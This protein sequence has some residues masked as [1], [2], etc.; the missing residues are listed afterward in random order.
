MD[1][2]AFLLSTK[3]QLE[4]R[5][6]RLTAIPSACTYADPKAVDEDVS[7]SLIIIT[8]FWFCMSEMLEFVHKYIKSI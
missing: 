2:M 8:W 1:N 5:L 6:K 3:Q 4:R 7:N